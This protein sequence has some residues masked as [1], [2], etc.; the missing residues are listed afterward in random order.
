MP[1]NPDPL[2]DLQ[3]QRELASRQLAEL[4]RQIEAAK[5]AQTAG[6]TARG[7]GDASGPTPAATGDTETL[8]TPDPAGAHAS[9]RRGCFLYAA[10]LLVLVLALLAAIYLLWYRDRPLIFVDQKAP[11]AAAKPAPA[12]P[13]K[14]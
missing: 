3:R 14:K 11:P 7:P 5:A 10:A 6:T 12:A 4:N 9:T 8:Y 1:E 13:S 2:A